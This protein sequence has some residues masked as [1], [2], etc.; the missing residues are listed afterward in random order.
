MKN[1]SVR[2]LCL[3]WCVAAGLLMGALRGVCKTWLFLLV[4][5]VLLISAALFCAYTRPF[6]GSKTARL[7]IACVGAAAFAASAVR[8]IALRG[9][10]LIYWIRI[11]FLVIC[12]A[13]C[14]Y[15]LSSSEGDGKG[16]ALLA[17]VLYAGFVLLLFYRE[18]ATDPFVSDYIIELAA[19]VIGLIAVYFRAV[20]RFEPKRNALASAFMALG[21][22]C[23][24]FLIACGVSKNDYFA[25]SNLSSD[26]IFTAVGYLAFL[27]GGILFETEAE[28][29]QKDEE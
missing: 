13:A 1:K 7:A 28:K 19:L 4:S 9:T 21:V 15:A 14:L 2:V 29:T 18:S 10:G 23:V 11:L 16:L 27:A 26:G 24:C 17:P 8:N 20:P 22:M 25:V 6:K 12:M 5:T 3:V